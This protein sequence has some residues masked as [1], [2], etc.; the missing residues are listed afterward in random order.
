[1]NYKYITGL[2]LMGTEERE[3]REATKREGKGIPPR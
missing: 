3:G 1:M 2:L